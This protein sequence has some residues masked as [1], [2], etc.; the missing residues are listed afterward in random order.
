MDWID[1]RIESVRSLFKS[2]LL[3]PLLLPCSGMVVVLILR[4]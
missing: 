3:S 4:N 1:W 2:L